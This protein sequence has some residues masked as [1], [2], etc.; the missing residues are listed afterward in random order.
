MSKSNARPRADLGT[1]LQARVPPTYSQAIAAAAAAEATSMSAW[2]RQAIRLRLLAD[3][4]GTFLSGTPS[5]NE[6]HEA[7][8]AR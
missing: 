4:F 3:G 7:Q 8:H 2:V 5:P 6:G 1:L